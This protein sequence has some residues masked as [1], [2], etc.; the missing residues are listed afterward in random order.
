MADRNQKVGFYRA[1]NKHTENNSDK[2]TET[3]QQ[4]SAEKNF[5]ASI[6]TVS[7][8][9]NIRYILKYWFGVQRASRIGVS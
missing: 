7:D 2:R 4:E 6:K 3:W 1:G 8:K 9:S 5:L